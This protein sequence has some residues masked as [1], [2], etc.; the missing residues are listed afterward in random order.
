MTLHKLRELFKGLPDLE[1]GLVRIHFNRASPS[2][3]LRVLH[4]LA[5]VADVFEHVHERDEDAGAP[6]PRSTVKSKLLKHIVA[7]LPTISVAV[8]A[9]LLVGNHLLGRIVRNANAA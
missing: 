2:E 9:L 8:D 1:R 7:T 4:A 5:R 6:T 3:L